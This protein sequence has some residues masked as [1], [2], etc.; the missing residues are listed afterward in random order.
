MMLRST[1]RNTVVLESG[2][3]Q[4]DSALVDSESQGGEQYASVTHHVASCVPR[5]PASSARA[6]AMTALRS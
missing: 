5:S 2:D 6:S 3:K 1:P 4:L